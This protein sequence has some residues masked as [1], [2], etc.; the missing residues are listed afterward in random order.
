MK[1]FAPNPGPYSFVFSWTI[2]FFL[3]PAIMQMGSS[4]EARPITPVE[5]RSVES[6]EKSKVHIV[7][8]QPGSLFYNIWG[9]T[10]LRVYD[11]EMD[12]TFLFDYG[13][14]DMD[15]MFLIRFIGGEEVYLLAMG[16]WNENMYYFLKE[17]R[18]LYL[19]EV[20][21]SPEQ[22]REFL[23]KLYTEALPK[24]RRY[25][26][27]HF[28]NNC[29]TKVRDL[30]NEVTNDNL[31]QALSKTKGDHT[32]RN[33][34]TAYAS[35][36]P[37]YWLWMNTAMN[38]N[39]DRTLNQYEELFLP[40]PFMQGM[41]EYRKTQIANG[42]PP[43]VSEIQT[44]IPTGPSL[45]P[46]HTAFLWRVYQMVFVAMVVAFFLWPAFSR[47][48]LARVLNLIGVFTFAIPAGFLGLLYL[49]FWIVSPHETFHQN[50][51]IF[52]LNPFFLY[53][54]FHHLR[55]D[56][57]SWKTNLYVY[58]A[59]VAVPGILVL[60][61]LTGIIEQAVYPGAL[62]AGFLLT[63]LFFTVYRRTMEHQKGTAVVPSPYGVD[64]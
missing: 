37:L 56:R 20:H 60:V 1:K 44:K 42:T 8:R 24:N 33:Q 14:F 43:L 3:F 40:I 12:K 17:D 4:L 26:Y 52:I 32:Y 39:A 46:D 30:L 59:Y 51:N 48:K 9:H 29:T 15:P 54:P 27:H 62:A 22:K 34:A 16:Y 23:T 63:I 6:L 53:L 31:K 61:R 19:Q 2:L 47:S 50:Y 58:G 10:A 41:D 57:F 18:G 45:D 28:T 36:M 13:V 25:Y 5:K 64:R 49:I 11:A 21:L 35:F 7:T 55:L 38:E